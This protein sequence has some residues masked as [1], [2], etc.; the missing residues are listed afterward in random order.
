M[1][2]LPGKFS[3]Y[4]TSKSCYSAFEVSFVLYL[5]ILIQTRGPYYAYSRITQEHENS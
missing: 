1:E 4:G 3:A 5:F 2:T